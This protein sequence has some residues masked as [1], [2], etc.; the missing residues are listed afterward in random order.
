MD[1]QEIVLEF[2][3]AMKSNDFVKASE[4]LSADFEGYWP[5]S[6]ELVIGRANFVAINRYYPA[7]GSWQFEINSIVSNGTEVVT[8]VS[9][10]DGS[11]VARAITFHTVENGLI[12]KQKEFWPDPMK[13]QAWRSQ[14]VDIVCE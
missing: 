9:I 10:T 8:D 1:S 12:R 13:A 2:W 6:S 3:D 11:Q 14:W 4:W 5:Q 7:T